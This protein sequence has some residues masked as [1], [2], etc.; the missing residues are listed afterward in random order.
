MSPKGMI[1][2]RGEAE[3]TG[4]TRALLMGVALGTIPLVQV[5]CA[6]IEEALN[7]GAATQPQAT[8]PQATDSTPGAAVV[9]GSERELCDRALASRQRQD[10]EALISRYP[11]A[12]CIPSVLAAQSPQTLNQIS[13]AVLAALPPS[14]VRRI[15]QST[16]AQLRLPFA[17]GSDRSGGVGGGSSGPY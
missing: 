17:P 15:P 9:T 10:V 1:M 6:Q 12:G 11:S 16:R 8:Q 3:K 7:T 13:P 4:L 5:G 14:T 2:A